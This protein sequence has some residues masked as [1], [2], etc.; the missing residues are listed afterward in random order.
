MSDSQS[1][2]FPPAVWSLFDKYVHG[3]IS[4]R[5]FIDR[6]SGL[7]VAG[8]TGAALLDAILGDIEGEL[9]GQPQADD[10]TLLTARV[11]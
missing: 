10:L 11:L 5:E 6:A 9:A 8:M 2:K 3:S 1:T 4:R 7:A